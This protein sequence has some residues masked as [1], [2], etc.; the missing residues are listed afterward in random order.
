MDAP[1]QEHK[2]HRK[3]KGP[4]TA[5]QKA[6]AKAARGEGNRS[7]NPRAFKSFQGPGGI[8]GAVRSLEQTEKKLH[9][10]AIDR[11]AEV[12]VAPPHV[13][14]VVGPPKVGKSTLI[15]SLV[16]HYTGQSLPGDMWGPITI[17]TG[18]LRRLTLIECPNDIN[19]MVDVAKIADLVLLMVDGSYGFEL[20]VFEFLSVAQVHGFM[21][22][23]G[24][25]THL[26]HFKTAR[27]LRRTKKTLKNR[28]WTEI[29]NGAKLFYFSG[30]SGG[31]YPKSEVQ[32]LSR[33]ISVMRFRPLSWRN[34]HAGLVVDRME[35]VTE[36][37][38]LQAAPSCDRRV[39]IYGYV[40][41]TYLRAGA[42]VHVAGVGDY[43][44][45]AVDALADPC[46][47]PDA[48]PKTA[49]KALSQKEKRIYAPMADLGDL[50]YDTDAVYINLPNSAVRFSRPADAEAGSH[51][52]GPEE[53]SHDAVAIVR[54]LQALDPSSSMAT[55]LRAAPLRLTAEAGVIEE[56]AMEEE[57]GGEEN[58][59]VQDDAS[60]EDEDGD[61]GQGRGG[62]GARG[63]APP[64]WRRLDHVP[65]RAPPLAS[66]THAPVHS[67]GGRWA[68]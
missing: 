18:K 10:P 61:G 43:E 26:D 41:G 40:H 3:S 56:E 51:E 57:H 7:N 33:F 31:R 54:R 15:R 27:A 8:R 23:M 29:Y 50:A 24:V 1:P 60:E 4:K 9:A 17:V 42:P 66:Q 25:L 47:P 37:A 45:A 35:D 53:T 12:A 36:P 34:T 68:T 63:T 67:H 20:E 22:V 30:L 52:E 48:A 46:P 38:A 6:N 19:A 62:E 39:A 13:V 28:F 64:Q 59:G 16:K 2:A 14:A 44:P 21:R 55:R 11:S 58:D 5:K 65:L 49:R 32:N